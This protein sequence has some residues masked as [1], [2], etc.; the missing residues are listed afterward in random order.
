MN[1]GRVYMF[2]L[3]K[4]SVCVRAPYT[5]KGGKPWAMFEFKMERGP[6]SIIHLPY[7]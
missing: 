3:V 5:S 1:R 4:V 7:L 2:T 6:A